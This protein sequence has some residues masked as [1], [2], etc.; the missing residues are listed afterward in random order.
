MQ[1]QQQQQQSHHEPLSVATSV[2]GVPGPAGTQQLQPGQQSMMSHHLGGPGL[3]SAS[4]T[5]GQMGG[6]PQSMQQRPMGSAAAGMSQFQRG[7]PNSMA[8]GA[9]FPDGGCG[10]S[11]VAAM[12]KYNSYGVAGMRQPGANVPFSQHR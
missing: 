3:Q 7:G 2:W 10:T 9:M 4:A 12:Q 5:G 1:W 8:A 11:G 6:Y